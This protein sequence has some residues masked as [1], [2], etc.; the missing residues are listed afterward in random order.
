MGSPYAENKIIYYPDV[1]KA[2]YQGTTHTLTPKTIHF[3]PQNKCNHN[4]CFCS[5]RQS[6][7]KNSENFNAYSHLA[8]NKILELFDDFEELNVQ[9]LEITG[10]GEPLLHPEIKIILADLARRNFSTALVTNGTLLTSQLADLLFDTRLKWVRISIDAGNEDLYGIVRGVSPSQWQKA[11]DAVDQV[12]KR[13]TDQVVGLGFV[14]N[15]QNWHTV[16]QFIEKA[17]DSGVDNVRISVAFTPKGV[18]ILTKDEYEHVINT[19]QL[20]KKLERDDFKIIS[21]VETRRKNLKQEREY[22][23]CAVKDLLCVIEGTGNV[24][25]CCTLAGSKHGKWGNITKMRF[26]DLWQKTSLLRKVFDIHRHCIGACLYDG[27]NKIMQAIANKPD[28][29]EFI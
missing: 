8:M 7:W 9:G 16:Y 5:Y 19:T 26:K 3:M 12:I 25:A 6:N 29:L 4:C 10:G 21:M 1:V 17:A 27:R 13:R 11:W 18:N 22:D 23:Y 24:F 28:H 20:A 14:V 15:D 2:L